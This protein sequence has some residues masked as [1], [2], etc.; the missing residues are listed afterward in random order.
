M[1]TEP[2]MRKKRYFGIQSHHQSTNLA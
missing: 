2:I 1:A